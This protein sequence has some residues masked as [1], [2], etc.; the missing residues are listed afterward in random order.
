MSYPKT[1]SL[2]QSKS[3]NSFIQKHLTNEDN[4]AI[5]GLKFYKQ[6]FMLVCL[7]DSV[8]VGNYAGTEEQWHEEDS[9][10]WPWTSGE[11]KETAEDFGEKLTDVTY[12]GRFIRWKVLRVDNY[13]MFT[14]LSA[15]NS[16]EP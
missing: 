12:I 13:L 3:S 8:Y 16:L 2:I 14:L 5:V 6:T 11:V 7:S 10:L 15:L 4:C 1:V 9:G